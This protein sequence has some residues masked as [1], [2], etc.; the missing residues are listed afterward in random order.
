MRKSTARAPRTILSRRPARTAL[1]HSAQPSGSPVADADEQTVRDFV[2]LGLQ[3][4][5]ASDGFTN[6]Y[7]DFVEIVSPGLFPEG[8]SPRGTSRDRAATS[9]NAT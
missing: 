6:V 1:F 8:N 4:G 2:E 5:R 3:A 7:M 9:S